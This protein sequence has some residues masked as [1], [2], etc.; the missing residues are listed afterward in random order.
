[1][2]TSDPGQRGRKPGVGPPNAGRDHQ[3]IPAQDR[4]E[5]ARS[6]MPPWLPKALLLTALAVAGF[7]FA[8]WLFERLR[9]LLILLLLAQ[10]L[11]FA[12]EPAVNWLAR[13][14]WR[15]GWAT[16]FVMLAVTVVLLGFIF[17][18]GSV[19]VSQISTLADRLPSYVD[20]TLEWINDTFDANLS[21]NRIRDQLT[22]QSGPLGGFAARVAQNAVG[23]GTGLLGAIFQFFTV[24]LF[25][26]Y[27][28]AD[29][30]RVRRG[31]LSM[32][33]PHRQRE[34]TR[35]WEIAIDKTGGYIYSRL[36]LGLISGISHY[37]VL[38]VL[39]VP[40]ALALALWIG[41]VSQLIPT[42]GTYLAAALPIIVAL[43]T[44][45]TDALI[46]LIFIVIYQQI[47]NYLLAPRITAHTLDI[48]PAVAF[49]SVI[50]GAAVLGGVG[51][52]LAI[53]FTAIVQ[54]FV[55]TYIQR[56]EVEEHPLAELAREQEPDSAEQS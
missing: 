41:L 47:E 49:G 46:L 31:L 4:P 39:G 35:A 44:D 3:A 9:G 2:G 38:R 15:R 1:M 45:P 29:G 32:L 34:A 13:R 43:V 18:V 21:V 23:F 5:P 17:A 10:F 33:P 22:G 37:F 51:A 16:G 40:F 48:H 11:A 54:T 6:E 14:G 27:L 56:Y 12:L 19:V 20:S 24:L 7:I 52:L 53:P 30:P 55:G 25:A 36:L 42:V 50:A 26:F 8:W 28:C